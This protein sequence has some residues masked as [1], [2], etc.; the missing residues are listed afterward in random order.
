MFINHAITR[1]GYSI[2]EL[3]G[4][5]ILDL[6]HPEDREKAKYGIRERR[7][8]ERRT[9]FMEIQLLTKSSDSVPF[10]MQFEN[11]QPDSTFLVDAEGIYDSHPPRKDSFLGTQGIARDIT[12]LKR[13]EEQLR[14][15]QKMEAIGNLAGGIAH[16][17]N[18]I[19]AGII[20]HISLLKEKAGQNPDFLPELEIIER[21]SWR[22]S[23]L[24]R[25][26]LAFSRRTDYEEHLYQIN[27][28]IEDVL[29]IIRETIGKN[30]TIR[31]ALSSR[32][33]QLTGDSDR[34]KQ[35]IMN[36]CLNGCEAMPD[37][38]T[39]TIKTDIAKLGKEDRIS[40]PMPKPGKY[41][42]VRVSDTGG[43]ISPEIRDHIFEPFFSTKDDKTG[44]G[45]GLF[46][47]IGSVKRHGGTVMVEKTP[48]GG[49]TFTIYLPAKN[50][51]TLPATE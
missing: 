37:G 24:I 5:K 12:R 33:P 28:V 21:L 42:S 15:V 17:F 18:N 43:G 6:I 44:T 40:Y 48:G 11:A 31:T 13:L 29:S 36:L 20:G 16:D 30:V 47:V 34:I 45:L 10:E 14:H 23:R 2:E 41:V 49:S 39:L 1:Y 27:T 25:S 9:R 35:S 8:G 38:G 3:I 19:L 50:I 46:M 32:I 4:T 7:T 26:L 51:L 22:G